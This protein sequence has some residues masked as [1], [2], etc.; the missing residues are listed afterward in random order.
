[1][2]RVLLALLGGVVAAPGPDGT[3]YVADPAAAE[4]RDDGSE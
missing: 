4:A 2:S 3:L 1:M